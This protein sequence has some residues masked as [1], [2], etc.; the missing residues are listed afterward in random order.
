MLKRFITAKIKE[1][2]ANTPAIALLGV[3]Q[4][5]K[6]TLAKILMK[7]QDSIYLDLESSADVLKL[8]DPRSFFH[9]HKDKLIILDEIQRLPNIFT[10]LRCVIDIN[11]EEGSKIYSLFTT[12][13]CIYRV[14]ASIV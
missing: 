11:R 12:G 6:T 13:I 4:V 10:E 7:E 8:S 3:R 14:N 5:G 2:R 9:I 1:S